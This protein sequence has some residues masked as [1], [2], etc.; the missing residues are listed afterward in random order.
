MS[1]KPGARGRPPKNFMAGLAL[2]LRQQ[3]ELNQRIS[4]LEALA[5]D[6]IKLTL[7]Q[8]RGLGKVDND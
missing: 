7:R 5:R 8:A 1:W 6:Q 3:K 4:R 2:V